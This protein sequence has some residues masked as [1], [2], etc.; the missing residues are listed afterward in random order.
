MKTSGPHKGMSA[1]GE[2]I[3]A[4]AD[5][6]KGEL[7]PGSFSLAFQE[8]GKKGW[9][10]DVVGIKAVDKLEHGLDGGRKMKAVLMVRVHG[11]L[12]KTQWKG[13]STKRV[14]A[15]GVKAVTVDS[16]ADIEKLL[17]EG[18]AQAKAA[19]KAKHAHDS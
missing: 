12:G 3:L 17:K 5:K 1:R 19:W 10:S 2:R 13:E 8:I 11:G 16:L 6:M 4:K 7:K 18:P 15:L 9:Q 14:P